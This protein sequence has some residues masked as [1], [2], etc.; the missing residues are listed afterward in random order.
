MGVTNCGLQVVDCCLQAITIELSY[1]F[2]N[3]PVIYST[4]HHAVCNG[5]IIGHLRWD[6]LCDCEQ[7]N[8]KIN[9]TKGEV[10]IIL[11]IV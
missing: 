4:V 6:A 7:P 3:V 11:C 8:C 1:P 9:L 2:S 10:L 5:Q